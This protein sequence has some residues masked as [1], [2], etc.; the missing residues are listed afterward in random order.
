MTK[1]LFLNGPNLGRLGTRKPEIYGSTTL[2][3][4]E[5]TAQAQAAA[6]GL[7]L[8][9]AQRNREGD[10]I[11]LIEENAEAAGLVINPG[12]L[13]MAGWSLRDALEEFAGIKIEVHI[14]N[15]WAREAF[16]HDSVLSAVVDSVI[17]GLGVNGYR[18]AMDHL[19]S[20]LRRP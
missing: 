6:E 5:A 8:I 1:I 7:V 11:D 4:V 13:M 15:V 10:L 2:A 3:Q 12:A 19:V 20:R 17:V 14:S 16:R 9:A 18:L